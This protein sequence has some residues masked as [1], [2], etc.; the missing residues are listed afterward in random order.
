MSR[1]L[2][3]RLSLALVVCG[4]VLAP[5]VS[6]LPFQDQDGSATNSQQSVT[7]RGFFVALWHGATDWARPQTQV[8]T[9]QGIVIIPVPYPPYFI[10]INTTGGGTGM[11]VPPDGAP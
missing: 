5:A 6:A 11:S 8:A 9:A 7:A 1:T 10:I 2:I 4:L 3:S